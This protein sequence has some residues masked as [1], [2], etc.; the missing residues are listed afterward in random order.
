MKFW[1]VAKQGLAGIEMCKCLERQKAVFVGSSHH[2]A[3]VMSRE[4]LE[5]FYQK[6]RPTHIINCSANVNVDKAENEEKQLAYD[7]NV[8]GTVHLA[9]L[10]KRHDV[11]LIHIS[12]D[13]VFDGEKESEY[14]E[15]DPVNPINEYGK[16]KCMGEMLMVMLYPKAVSVRTASLYGLAKEGLV[17][18]IIKALKTQEEVRHISD[19]ISSPTYTYDLCEALFDIRD[20]S[21]IFHF[22]NKGHTSR[23]G[24]VEEIKRILEE[25]GVPLKCRRVVGVTRAESKRP[26]MRPRRSILSNKKIEPFLTHP[27]RTWQEALRGYIECYLR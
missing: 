10:A 22:T 5:A 18:G 24:L 17:S 11:R 15:T 3:D 27:I 9:E 20:Q 8:T 21:G 2:E 25:R 4:A 16:S 6:H 12:T 23:V 1:V 14:S 13:Y 26:A 7:I 19:Q